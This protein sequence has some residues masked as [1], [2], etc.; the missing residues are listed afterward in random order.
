M[1]K[2]LSIFD[3]SDTDRWAEYLSIPTYLLPGD[4]ALESR[5]LVGDLLE[6]GAKFR[7]L[8]LGGSLA[9]LDTSLD[10]LDGRAGLLVVLARLLVLL[11]EASAVECV[12]S[13]PFYKKCRDVWVL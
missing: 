9:L 2:L 7:Q 3:G 12:E 6:A 5:H 8:R 11:A 10:L 13:Q 1:T 4:V